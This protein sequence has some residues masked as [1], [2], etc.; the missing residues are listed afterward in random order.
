MQQEMKAEGSLVTDPMAIG[1]YLGGAALLSFP[2]FYWQ[3]AVSS[4]YGLLF[5]LLLFLAALEDGRTGYISDAW[6]LAIAALGAVRLA[7]F[8]SL[9]DAAGAFGV[10]LIFAAVCFGGK[11]ILKRGIMGEGDIFFAGAAALWLSGAEVLL[12]LWI[13]FVAGGLAAAVLLL[14]GRKARSEGVAFAPFL[15]LGGGVTY[16]FGAEMLRWYASFF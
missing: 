8:G 5:L 16:V 10:S 3:E 11:W 13:A 1:P 2:V 6:S 14:T 7:F 15:A 9:E 4:W 12:F